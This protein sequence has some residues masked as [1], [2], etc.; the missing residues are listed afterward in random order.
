MVLLVLDPN[1]TPRF[2]SLWNDFMKSLYS[3]SLLILIAFHLL[4]SCFNETLTKQ[5]FQIWYSRCKR[6]NDKMFRQRNLYSE[7]ILPFKS[8]VSNLKLLFFQSFIE[9]WNEKME[10][11]IRKYI[12][13]LLY[14]PI[15]MTHS[16]TYMT[17][18]R[19]ENESRVPAMSTFWASGV[20]I[21]CK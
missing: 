6:Q 15:F 8:T 5:K 20:P 18:W 21:R 1:S 12:I 4:N 2:T 11:D 3:R 7:F 17:K 16:S 13:R 10:T 19:L 9:T 14:T